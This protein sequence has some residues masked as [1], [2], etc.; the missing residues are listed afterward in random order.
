MY[1]TPTAGDNWETTKNKLWSRSRCSGLTS[2]VSIELSLAICVACFPVLTPFFKQFPAIA[3]IIPSIRSRLT[4]RTKSAEKSGSWRAQENHTSRSNDVERGA[5]PA[6]E[7]KMHSSWRRPE[8][9]RSRR[10]TM[11][12]RVRPVRR[13]CNPCCLRIVS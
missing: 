6:E 3:S 7:Y 10:L 11:N 9:G 13:R 1:N 12:V 8:N 5:V 2:P 4:S